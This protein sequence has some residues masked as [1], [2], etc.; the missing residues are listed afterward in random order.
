[1]LGAGESRESAAVS[2]K[3]GGRTGLRK[4]VSR[5][6]ERKQIS[7]APTAC[8]MRAWIRPSPRNNRLVSTCFTVAVAALENLSEMSFVLVILTGKGC[9]GVRVTVAN[10][11][12]KILLSGFA[13]QANVTVHVPADRSL[14]AVNARGRERL[15]PV[16]G[17]TLVR[18]GTRAE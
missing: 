17:E 18:I 7:G 3:V 6:R 12:M 15:D 16:N 8:Q 2:G 1:M 4:C 13:Q 10:P 11:G 9:T 5:G 14:A